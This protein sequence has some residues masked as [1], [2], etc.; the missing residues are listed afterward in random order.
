M[1]G[2]QWGRDDEGPFPETLPRGPHH[3]PQDL[4]RANQRRRILLAS[5]GV[6]AD[7]GFAAATVK[8]LVRSA[9]VSRATFYAIFAD[10]EECMVTLHDEV[11]AWL[12]RE[13]ASEVEET[14]SWEAGV[15]V[16]VSKTVELLAGDPRLAAVCVV[17]GQANRLPQI[18]ARRERLVEDLCEGL[19]LG[20]ADAPHGGDLP[21]IL[22]PALVCGAIYMI[23]RA[24][25][26]GEGSDGNLATELAELMLMHYCS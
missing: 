4:V 26:Y 9:G 8:D 11:L 6:F 14:A 13:V 3:L 25:A 7:R 22:E 24:T 15:R 17:E 21:E 16:A 10:K 18:R 23:G 1:S 19:R 2:T 20:R 12:W 5:L